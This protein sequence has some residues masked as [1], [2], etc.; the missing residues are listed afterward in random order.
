MFCL[1]CFRFFFKKPEPIRDVSFINNVRERIILKDA[2]TTVDSMKGGWDSV[3]RGE[4]K[5]IEYSLNQELHTE[6]SIDSTLQILSH[7]ADN[8]STW[9]ENRSIRQ[10]IDSKNRR[11]LELWIQSH[12][13][14][15]NT[16]NFILFSYIENLL[17]F[18][19][20]WSIIDIIGAGADKLIFA[21]E[22]VI[23]KIDV[24]T[25]D[26]NGKDEIETTDAY[27]VEVYKKVININIPS[28]Y[29]LTKELM[30]NHREFIREYNEKMDELSKLY[31]A[32]LNT[33]RMAISNR[34]LEP[35][36]LAMRNPNNLD[37]LRDSPE[38]LVAIGIEQEL[39]LKD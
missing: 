34:E 27:K 24:S 22:C 14:T 30:N 1:R 21:I 38:Y 35:L 23:A 28:D 15:A 5:S 36:Q 31:E 4:L 6:D 32:Q 18:I 3:R 29:E 7:I 26:S 10:D 2:I 37:K 9:A 17:R 12:Q 13:Y 11:A 16:N 33:L 20:D 19:V 25:L 8:W 39:L